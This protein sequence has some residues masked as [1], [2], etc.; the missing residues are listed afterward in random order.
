MAVGQ[1]QRHHSEGAFI[2]AMT[3]PRLFSASWV[4][5]ILS[6]SLS[7]WAVTLASCKLLKQLGLKQ[8]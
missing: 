5:T 8:V 6:T 4:L 3:E 7:M 1:Q 2:I